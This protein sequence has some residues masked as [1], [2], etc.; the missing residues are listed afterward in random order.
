MNL[1]WQQLK[2][3]M[4]K[5]WKVFILII[6]IHLIITKTPININYLFQTAMGYIAGYNPTWW[7]IKTYI[8]IIIMFPLFF[9]FLGEC[10]TPYKDLLKII[11]ICAFFTHIFKQII[12]LPLLGNLKNTIYVVP[13]KAIQENIGPVLMGAFVCKYNLFEWLDSKIN[14]KHRC[15]KVLFYISAIAITFFLRY[16]NSNRTD[17]DY[18][19]VVIFSYSILRLIKRRNWLII[20]GKYS[21]EMWLVHYF[22]LVLWGDFQNI[23]FFP[24]YSLFIFGWFIM[25]NLV[26][27][28]IIQYFWKVIAKIVNIP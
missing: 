1:I 6:P 9:T 21:T 18:I 24:K 19:L 8:C 11:L 27:A 26:L 25:I 10:N 15:Q 13:L 23:I 14:Y 28:I 5:Y 4:I 16:L 20:L 3:F 7:F 2:S 22:V 12:S 17:Y